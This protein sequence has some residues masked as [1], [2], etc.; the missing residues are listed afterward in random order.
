MKVFLSYRRADSQHIADRIY[1]RL[2]QSFGRDA[3]FKDVDSIP[4][5]SDF[6]KA[7][8]QAVGS[9]NVL[10]AVIGKQWLTAS[11][12][13][14]QR[15]L[16]NGNDVV[17][18]EIETALRRGIPVVPI[19]IDGASIPLASD[20]PKEL[21]DLPFQNGTPVRADPDFHNDVD[22]LIANIKTA[23]QTNA[24]R[25]LRILVVDEMQF[26]RTVAAKILSG[27]GHRVHVCGPD[28][29]QDLTKD[30]RF[31][32]IC[33]QAQMQGK[34]LPLA[35]SLRGVHHPVVN[36][37][38]ILGMTTDQK[39]KQNWLE[40]GMDGCLSRPINL[41]EFREQ[42]QVLLSE[43][44]L[45]E[46]LIRLGGNDALL[47]E[48]SAMFVEDM[49]HHIDRLGVSIHAEDRGSVY[50]SAHNLK[51]GLMLFNAESAI[52]L[53]ERLEKMGQS[54]SLLGAEQ[55]FQDLQ[56]ALGRFRFALAWYS[57]AKVS[58]SS[59]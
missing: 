8:T 14:G 31:D 51:N 54:N 52:K 23:C 41:L 43:V 21:A 4:L 30:E 28:D 6:R 45:N 53:A 46:A 48:M 56:R 39:A 22:R 13:T 19:F 59:P 15:R 5:G 24:N 18:M 27:E 25:M 49:V 20:L 10:L 17:R 1:D 42:L 55:L 3:I 38:P 50:G 33:L 34:A 29:I 12:E 40:A 47:N 35:A 16:H 57:L 26:N 2:L 9:C 7:I 36:Y 11:D 44:N 37:V 32:L 58:Y